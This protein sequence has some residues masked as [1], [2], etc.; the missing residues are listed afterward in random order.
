[1]R[2]SPALPLDM[3]FSGQEN[4]SVIRKLQSGCDTLAKSAAVLF[5]SVDVFELFALRKT[6]FTAVF[7][8][9]L[10]RTLRITNYYFTEIHQRHKSEWTSSRSELSP[11]CCLNYH[12]SL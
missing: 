6:E 1:M 3:H 12:I 10:F 11:S 9:M 7:H 5:M 2:F 8:I 4:K